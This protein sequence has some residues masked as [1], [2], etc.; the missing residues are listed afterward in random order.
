MSA[1]V[2]SSPEL[3][4]GAARA[5]F[6]T[7]WAAAWENA[8]AENEAAS[9]PWSGGEDLLDVAPATPAK[10]K[11]NARK[12][13]L[14]VKQANRGVDWNALYAQS[15]LTK[16]TFGHYLAMEAMDEGVGLWEY[17]PR[18]LYSVPRVESHLDFDEVSRAPGRR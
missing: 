6:V 5:F 11:T 18:N 10:F 15:G 17:V 7:A 14:L 2:L 8:V 9:V 1:T 13:I 4:D 3:I 16:D 12:F